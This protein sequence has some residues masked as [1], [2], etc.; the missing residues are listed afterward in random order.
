VLHHLVWGRSSRW[1]YTGSVQRTL[2]EQAFGRIVGPLARRG[3]LFAPCKRKTCKGGYFQEGLKKTG[4]EIGASR[5]C[6]FIQI[7]HL[8]LI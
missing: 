7:T 1:S 3:R 5:S 8:L 4:Q 2:G 6:C